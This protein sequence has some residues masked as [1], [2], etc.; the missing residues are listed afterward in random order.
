LVFRFRDALGWCT[1]SAEE[2]GS[3]LLLPHHH[4][5]EDQLSKFPSPYL[6]DK[7][8]WG[9]SGKKSAVGSPEMES[10]LRQEI[11]FGK[12]MNGW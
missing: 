10:D 5:K 1:A 12:G 7:S 11:G 2:Q 3:L 9:W 8:Y 6:A 4:Q